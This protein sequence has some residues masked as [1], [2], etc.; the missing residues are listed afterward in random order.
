MESNSLGFG[1][2]GHLS[3]LIVLNLAKKE[4]YEN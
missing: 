3:F 4:S 1:R 2:L